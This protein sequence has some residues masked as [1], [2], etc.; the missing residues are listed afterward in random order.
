MSD[1]GLDRHPNQKGQDGSGYGH[2]LDKNLE[3]KAPEGSKS[4]NGSKLR[5]EKSG[6]NHMSLIRI[7]GARMDPKTQQKNTSCTVKFS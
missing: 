3:V 1:H 5:I 7:P 2:E 4:G 6:S